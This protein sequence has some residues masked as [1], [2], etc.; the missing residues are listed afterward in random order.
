MNENEIFEAWLEDYVE[1]RGPFA[2]LSPY[3]K[4]IA[5]AAFIEGRKL[6]QQSPPGE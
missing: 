2:P 6:L 3:E 1:N 4:A 5:K